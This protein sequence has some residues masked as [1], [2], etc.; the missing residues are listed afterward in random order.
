M[1]KVYTVKLHHDESGGFDLS[2]DAVTFEEFSSVAEYL[3][4]V[5]GESDL[6]LI[7]DRDPDWQVVEAADRQ[8]YSQGSAIVGWRTPSGALQ[9]EL[10]CTE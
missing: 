1:I 3:E 8:A 10:V 9:C 2:S 7:D 5:R 4:H 6:R